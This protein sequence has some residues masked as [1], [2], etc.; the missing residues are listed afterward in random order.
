MALTAAGILKEGLVRAWQR[1]WL[2]HLGRWAFQLPGLGR[3]SR[4]VA[5]RFLPRGE[6]VWVQIA[7]GLAAGLWIK[8]QPYRELGYFQGVPEPGIQEQFR[9]YLEPGDCFYDVGAHI[10]FYSLVAARLVGERGCVV[11]FEP[12]SANATVLEE[13][14]LKNGFSQVEVVGAA[15]WSHNGRVVFQRYA[16]DHPQVTSR[17]GAVFSGP[18]LNHRTD[19]PEVDSISL[20]EFAQNHRVPAMIK[21]DVE[22]AECEV[23]KGAELLLTEIKPILLCEVHYAQTA[24]FLEDELSRKGYSLDWLPQDPRYLQFPF[25][26]HVVA[27]PSQPKRG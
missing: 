15:V 27:R 11:A 5:Q 18:A 16:D 13:N 14:V 22:G 7:A 2:R 3:A 25:P 19:L 17:R 23:L 12:D 1:R 8:L 9:K 24:T 26:R 20:D 10:G 4:Q 21:I 6:R